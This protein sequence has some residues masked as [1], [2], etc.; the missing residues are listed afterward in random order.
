MWKPKYFHKMTIRT[1]E[2]TR[3]LAGEQEHRL[4][5]GQP[6]DRGRQPKVAVEHE[7]PNQARCDIREHIG[8]EEDHTE[9]D[10]ADDPPGDHQGDAERQRQLDEE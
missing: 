7:V 10:G 8:Q 5:A 1:A 3:V 9:P 4:Q 6:R 2:N